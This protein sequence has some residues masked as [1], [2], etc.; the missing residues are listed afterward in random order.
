MYEVYLSGLLDPGLKHE[1]M[2]KDIC[3]AKADAF[4]VTYSEERVKL[5]VPQRPI[6]GKDPIGP[7]NCSLLVMFAFVEW[8]DSF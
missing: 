4:F 3:E 5:E 8:F 2:K 1:G 7:G 6:E